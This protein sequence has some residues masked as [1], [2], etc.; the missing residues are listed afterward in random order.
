MT[1]RDRRAARAERLRGWAETRVE[2][3]SAQL[4]SYP[5]IRHDYAFN[6]QPG[7]IPFRARMIA[8]DDRAHE[9]LRKAASMASRAD[10]I[11]A[12]AERAIY[13]DD[14]DAVEK[15]SARIASLE[16]ERG[17]ITAYNA[18]CRKAG[19][20]T[21]EA[22]AILDDRQVE[23][24]RRLAAIGFLRPNGSMPAYATSNLSGNI[25][26]QRERLARLVAAVP[27]PVSAN[28][29]DCAGCERSETECVCFR[30]C[31]PCAGELRTY[32]A[33][34]DGRCLTCS[35]MAAGHDKRYDLPGAPLLC[36]S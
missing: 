22:L 9:S 20:A 21:A 30:G 13:S 23:D 19:K 12:A 36:L 32:V 28:A 15:L 25:S 1:Y 3:A 5:E 14:A 29:C 33:G 17:R 35:S 34:A 18:V 6:T 4:E 11:D 26:K 10:S 8:S 24:V 2:R 7:H 16:A 27:A 31:C